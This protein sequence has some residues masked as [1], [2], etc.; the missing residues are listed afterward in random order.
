M[1]KKS[2]PAA[3]QQVDAGKSMG[4]YMFGKNFGD[5]EG[6]TDPRLQ[7]KILAAESEYRP[8][9]SALELA[10]INT[11]WSG[12]DDQ[13]GYRDLLKQASEDSG[14]LQREQLALQRADDVSALQEYS[15]Q[16]VEAYRAA[17]PYSTDLAD[18]QSQQAKD[19]IGGGATGAENLLGK[20]GLEF[21]A[22]TGQLT[23]LEQRNMQQQAR[24][25]SQARGREMGTFGEYSEMQARM[26]AEL[27]KQE[28]EMQMGSALLGQQAGLQQQRFGQG[29]QALQS[30]F[31]MNRQMAGDI[32]STILG[33]PSSAIGLGQQGLGQATGLAAGQMGP[34]L[35]DPNMGVNMALQHQSN[36]T[37]YGGA[38]A[39][40]NASRSAGT[41]GMLGSLGGAAAIGLCWVARE[42]YGETNPKWLSFREWLISDSPQWFFK[43]YKNYG[44]RFAKFISDKPII[45]SIIRAW[46]N[47]KLK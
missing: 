41:M 19:I 23:P 47:T 36:M 43:L 7:E 9:Y 15:P 21:A 33:R 27:G 35:F 45:K 34:Q 39:Q 10:D 42:V 30:A 28:R 13:A 40:A 3:P 25:A 8:Q 5:F 18:L 1:G 16:V 37:N 6:V 12:T 31:G 22:S 26:S 14:Q 2:K 4:E 20:R 24:I 17:D 32:G 44:E 38:M 46:M 29:Q 11:M